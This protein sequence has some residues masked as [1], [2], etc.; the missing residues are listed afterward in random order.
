MSEKW[1]DGRMVVAVYFPYTFYIL[2]HEE[3]LMR[4][5]HNIYVYI[6]ICIHI[7]THIVQYYQTGKAVTQLQ[8]PK[9]GRKTEKEHFCQ[10][11]S[12]CQTIA[13]DQNSFYK[14]R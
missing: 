9:R 6:C 13:S 14:G 5:V 12:E 2:S 1:T 11:C 4:V 10:V 3:E 8:L 7:N